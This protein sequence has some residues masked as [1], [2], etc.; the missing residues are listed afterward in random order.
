MIIGVEVGVVAEHIM[1]SVFGV[2]NRA[3]RW[4]LGYEHDCYD[5]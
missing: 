4:L 3:W 5:V 1:P 2:Q